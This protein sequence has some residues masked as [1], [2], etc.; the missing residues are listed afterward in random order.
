M[1]KFVSFALA[2]AMLCVMAVG[3]AETVDTYTSASLTK[4]Y[5]EGDDLTALAKTLAVSGADIA[6][7]AQK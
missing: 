1:K 4:S 6:T 5:V 3:Y 7:K 2:L